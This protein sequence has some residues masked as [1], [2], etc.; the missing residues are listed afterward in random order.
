MLE[1]GQLLGGTGFG[2]LFQTT[3]RKV[4]TALTLLII[5]GLLAWSLTHINALRRRKDAPLCWGR[6]MRRAER[7][8]RD[9]VVRDMLGM[10]TEPMCGQLGGLGHV[11]T[12]N[13]GF[14]R[15]PAPSRLFVLKPVQSGSRGEREV[16]FYEYVRAHKVPG[17]ES[18]VCP[19]Y[20][21]V[22]PIPRGQAYILLHDLTTSMLKPCVLDVKLGTQT[23]EDEAPLAKREREAA[24]Y[25]PQATL[26]CRIVGMRLHASNDDDVVAFDKHW[27]YSL[28]NRAELERGLRLFVQ[29]QESILLF[30]RRIE[31]FLEWIST[32]PNELVFIS[33]SL[34]FVYDAANPS[35]CDVRLID[36]AHVRRDRTVDTGLIVGLTTLLK[37]F[38]AIQSSP[39]TDGSSAGSFA[40]S[41]PSPRRIK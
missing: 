18:F 25:P 19:Y 39:A 33:S 12:A 21:V 41:S 22:R 8:G 6:F 40:T 13:G 30:E 28:R 9:F 23:Y 37:L 16:A 7:L 34:L 14:L 27:G 29:E 17:L 31:S 11:E 15:F 2:G 24:K 35:C 36:F 32:V 3:V 26:G 4:P 1:D 38:R 5:L 20:G 10:I